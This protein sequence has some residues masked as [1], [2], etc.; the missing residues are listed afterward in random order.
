MLST[1]LIPPFVMTFEA[2][3]PASDVMFRS[4]SCLARSK[5]PITT[6]VDRLPNYS[7]PPPWYR[8][9]YAN[10]IDSR[11]GHFTSQPRCAFLLQASTMYARWSPLPFLSIP[12]SLIGLTACHGSLFVSVCSFFHERSTEVRV[13][14]VY[15]LVA[16][17]AFV[18]SCPPHEGLVPSTSSPSMIVDGLDKPC[19]SFH[20]LLG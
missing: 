7:P 6:F 12:S 2:C 10:V 8:R 20:V 9:R 15:S 3:G 14:P 17:C 11:G 16:P 19:F 5:L 18:R 13:L 4:T 1:I